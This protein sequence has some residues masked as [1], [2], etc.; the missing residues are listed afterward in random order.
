MQRDY[1]DRQRG[2]FKILNH[3]VQTVLTDIVSWGGGDDLYVHKLQIVLSQNILFASS[4]L[5]IGQLPGL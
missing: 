3:M 1:R 4:P 2:L 5:L